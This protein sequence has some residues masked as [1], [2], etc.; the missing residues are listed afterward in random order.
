VEPASDVW[1]AGVM[2]Y[3]L[4]TGRFPFDDWQNLGAVHTEAPV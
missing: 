1:A 2:A 4:L 3:Q